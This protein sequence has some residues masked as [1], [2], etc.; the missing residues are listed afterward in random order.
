MRIAFLYDCVYPHTIGGVERRLHELGRRLAGRGHEVH[1]FGMKWWDG[2]DSLQK[3]GIWIHGVSP[4]SPLYTGGR[5]AIPPA[6]RYA[7][8]LLRPL[9]AG[10]FDL[11]DAQ[12]FPY[13]HCLS[14]SLAAVA[15]HMPLVITWHEVW[16]PYWRE[17]LGPAGGLAGE[18]VERAVAHLPASMAAVSRTTAERLRDLGIDKPVEILPNGIDLRSIAATPPARGTWDL[19]YAGRLIPEKRVDLL[20]DS[21]P[22]LLAE[23]P[24]LKVLVIGDGPERAALEERA[25]RPGIAGHVSFSGFLPDPAAVIAH[26]KN[27]RVFVSPSVREG[28]GMGALEAMACGVPVVTV[29][30]PGNAVRERITP[31]TG[32]IARPTPR[33][34][35][36]KIRECLEDPSRFREG[37]TSLAAAYDWDAI[38]PRVEEYY[39]KVVSG[40]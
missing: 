29:D 1:H 40:G 11:V 22:G 7:G 38:V 9:L 13:L 32:R 30:N 5:R 10:G 36:E 2:P 15:R 37:C 24:S 14:A 20:I 39:E 34:L 27:A 35:G 18:L 31:L 28:F 12:Q 26:M 19:L 33:D 8:S 25:S 3:D 4:A 17:Y 21:V 16:G 6:A 23:F